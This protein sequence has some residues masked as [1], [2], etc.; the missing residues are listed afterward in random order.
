MVDENDIELVLEGKIERGA[1]SIAE[2]ESSDFGDAL[3]LQGSNDSFN[4]R[5]G[6]S[7]R[8]LS[9]PGHEVETG[10]AESIGGNRIFVEVV[11]DDDFIAGSCEGIGEELKVGRLLYRLHRIWRG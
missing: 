3:C 6:T 1:S 9:E 11:G 5:D 2:T 10:G 7:R 4:N 8:V